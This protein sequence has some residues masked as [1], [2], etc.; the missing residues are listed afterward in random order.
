MGRVKD[1]SSDQFVEQD[2]IYN[3]L[4]DQIAALRSISGLGRDI[5]SANRDNAR[6]NGEM[7]RS[8]QRIKE[9]SSG[10]R[11]YIN[12][13]RIPDAG[14]LSRN[15]MSAAGGARG[16]RDAV[17]QIPRSVTVDVTYRPMGTG[18]LVP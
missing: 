17:N 13:V 2:R 4:G 7:Q 6:L 10:V 15:M 14:P 16:V 3:K 1:V 8:M 18:N 12:Q 9:D 5:G 11:N